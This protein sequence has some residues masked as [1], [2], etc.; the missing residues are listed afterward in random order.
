[1]TISTDAVRELRERTG[2]G[3]LDCKRALEE[4]GGDLDRAIALLQQ[5]GY[6]AA[7]KRVERETMQGLIESYVHGGRIGV[8]VELNCETDFVA[9]TED[10]RNLAREL[11]L[12]IAS[13]NPLYVSQDQAPDGDIVDPEQAVLLRQPWIRDPSRTIEDLVRDVIAKTG[14]NVRIRRFARFELG[15]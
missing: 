3:V 1:M 2:A 14:E 4:T 12:Q 5:K 13:M 15:R 7:A 8:L 6:E 10:F 11:V 9:R